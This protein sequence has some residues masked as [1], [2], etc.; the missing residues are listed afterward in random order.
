MDRKQQ[1]DTTPITPEPPKPHVLAAMAQVP[2]I[3]ANVKPNYESEISLVGT[4]LVKKLQ[5]DGHS[6]AASQWAIHQLVL[7]EMLLAKT[8]KTELPSF[9]KRRV[10]GFSHLYGGPKQVVT[11]WGGGGEAEVGIPNGAHTP[12]EYFRVVAVD[13]LWNWWRKG[14]TA[15]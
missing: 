14:Q 6:L 13:K 1:I 9:G 3:L 5:N 10:V 12:F 2:E 11:S 4:T 7:D 15:E 8:I